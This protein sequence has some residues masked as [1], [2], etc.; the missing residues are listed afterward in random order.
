[1]ENGH[2]LLHH[3]EWAMNKPKSDI[4]TWKSMKN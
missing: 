3:K 2:K 1:M 4:E